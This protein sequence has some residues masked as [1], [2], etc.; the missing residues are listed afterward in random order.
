[1]NENQLERNYKRKKTERKKKEISLSLSSALSPL[2]SLSFILSPPPPPPRNQSLS[3]S[4]PFISAK[5]KEEKSGK[6]FPTFP[7]VFFFPLLVLPLVGRR[8]RRSSGRRSLPAASRTA[9]SA[10]APIGHV[11]RPESQVVPQELHDKRGVLV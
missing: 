6:H 3:I 1:M 2:S 10:V 8:C 5:E 7:S 11:A 9:A 4:L